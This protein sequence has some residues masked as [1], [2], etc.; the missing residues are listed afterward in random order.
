[1]LRGI[2]YSLSLL[3]WD[4]FG[5]LT[6]KNP[7][8]K[9]STRWAEAYRHL[10]RIGEIAQRPYSE[11]RIALRYELGELNERPHFHYLIG[12]LRSSN[13]HT[14]LHRA[15]YDWHKSNGGHAEI[16]L[17]VP[18]M[19][20]EAYVDKTLGGNLYEVGKFN[21]AGELVLSR[22]VLRAIATMRARVQAGRVYG[23]TVVQGDEVNGEGQTF[24]SGEGVGSLQQT[25]GNRIVSSS[26]ATAG[27]KHLASI[28]PVRAL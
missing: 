16:R 23:G 25:C 5:T 9:Q 21:K 27:E 7:L 13:L 19:D 20:G 10:H 2:A 26:S 4:F 12:E 22:S 14:V 17:Y 8:P 6:F 18:Q 1:M 3:E 11:L 24:A 28:T 15:A